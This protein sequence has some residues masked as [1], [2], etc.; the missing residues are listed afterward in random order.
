MNHP[1]AYDMGFS[2]I[3]A[4]R[5]VNGSLALV[6]TLL[7]TASLVDDYEAVGAGSEVFKYWAKYFL[8]SSMNL[9]VMSYLSLFMLR[10]AKNSSVGCGGSSH[11]CKM[12]SDLTAPKKYKRLFSETDI[13]A[14]F[15][16]SAVKVLLAAADINLP[17]SAIQRELEFFTLG[18]TELRGAL[19]EERN[20]LERFKHA[21][22]ETNRIAATSSTASEPPER[23]GSVVPAKSSRRGRRHL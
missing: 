12:P 16:N 1:N 4:I 20:Q 15:P 6:K 2:L 21:I 8:V 17:D 7:T 10:E 9:E 13:L 18:V 23:S 14:G 5:C 3:V 22:D 19:K 11:V